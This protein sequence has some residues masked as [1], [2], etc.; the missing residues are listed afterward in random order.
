MTF[1]VTVTSDTIYKCFV[2]VTLDNTDI[3]KTFQKD[4]LIDFVGKK[5][6]NSNLACIFCYFCS[7]IYK[8]V[9]VICPQWMC[10]RCL[11]KSKS[12]DYVR[13]GA[14]PKICW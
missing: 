7:V 2:E 9:C 8:V 6:G 1:K 4:V 11:P 13:A 10:Y 3:K 5:I 12:N 14:V